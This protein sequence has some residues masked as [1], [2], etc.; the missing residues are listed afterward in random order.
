MADETQNMMSHIEIKEEFLED[1]R[2][3]EYQNFQLNQQ[4]FATVLCPK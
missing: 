3:I 1:I 4:F 2:E